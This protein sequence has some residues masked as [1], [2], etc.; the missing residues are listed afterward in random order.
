MLLGIDF[1]VGSY[2]GVC[3]YFQVTPV[4]L[5]RQGERLPAAWPEDSAQRKFLDQ[6]VRSG[7][8]A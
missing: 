1:L 5:W 7:G 4:P 8:W 2:G 3:P 6:R